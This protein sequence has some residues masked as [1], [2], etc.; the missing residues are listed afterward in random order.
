MRR[1][2]SVGVLALAILAIGGTAYAAIPESNGTIHGCYRSDAPGNGAL[3]VIDSEDECPAGFTGLNWAQTSPSGVQ[4]YEI[5]EE[6]FTYGFSGGPGTLFRDV[7]CPA[8]KVAVGFS[9]RPDVQSAALKIDGAGYS[10][11]VTKPTIVPPAVFTFT[12]SIIC[13]TGGV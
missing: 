1:V 2:A 10:F 7:D 13:V 9:F 4:G 3:Y 8:G 11:T 5:V 6:T 12:E